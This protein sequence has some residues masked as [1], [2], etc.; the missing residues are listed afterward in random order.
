MQDRYAGDIGD[1]G[2]LGMLRQI[3]KSGLSI[4]VNW[5]LVPDEHHNRDGRHIGYLQNDIYSTCDEQLW[6]ALKGSVHAGRRSVSALE[7]A[8]ILPAAYYSEALDLA[9]RSKRDRAAI[10]A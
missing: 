2:K 9:G 3:A 8:S 4:G 6:P 1:F 10:R 7:S 5:Y